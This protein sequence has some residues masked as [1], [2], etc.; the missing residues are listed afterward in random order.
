MRRLFLILALGVSARA[1]FINGVTWEVEQGSSNNNGASFSPGVTGFATD[2]QATVGNTASPVFSSAS[3]NFVAGDVGAWLFIKSG[4]SSTPGFCKIASVAANAATL[5][6][7]AGTCTLYPSYQLSTVAGIAT[8]TG[9]TTLTWGIDYSQQASPQF[10]YT[11][12]VVATTTYTSVAHPVGVNV[13]GNGIQIISGTG[14]TPGFHTVISTSTITA[15]LDSTGGTGTCTS[16]LG[17]AHGTLAQLNT[18]LGLTNNITQLGFVKANATYQ[19]SSG[20]TFNPSDNTKGT[21]IQVAGYTTVRGDGGQATVQATASIT[22]VT[23]SNNNNLSNFTLRNFIL[24]CNAQ[25]TSSGL[26]FFA[27][28][29]SAAK[30]K[31]TNCTSNGIN[32]DTFSGI[33]CRNCWV[34]GETGGQSFTG[35]STNTLNEVCMWCFA[36]GGTVLGF[37]ISASFNCIWCIAANN[38]GA[39]TDGFNVTGVSALLTTFVNCISYKNGRHGLL[40]TSD[41]PA[42]NAPMSITNSVFYGNGGFG[43]DN[44]GTAGTA[45]SYGIFEDYN[46]FGAN[47]SGT[48]NNLIQGPNDVTL[49]GDPFA[50]GASLNFAPNN[51]SGAG[52]A[53]QGAGFPGTPLTGGTGFLDIGTFQHQVTGN[54]SKAIG[55]V[56]P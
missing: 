31:A 28:G 24:D 3:Y 14:C 20:V 32:F 25:T 35:G 7:S 11:D 51:T 53:L 44:N 26:L 56:G 46:A 41:T 16:N 39:N 48:V 15:T 6:A 5:T 34:A 8:V 29:N 1:A 12:M 33:T 47:T 50:N 43:I 55:F 40:W 18:D 52:L 10:A 17:G 49:T 37:N 19:V 9:P 42:G 21:S 30:I 45:Q 38:T 23:I 13:I 36:T 22:V 2:G 27:N 54:G 4:T